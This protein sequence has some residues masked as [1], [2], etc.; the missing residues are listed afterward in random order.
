MVEVGHMFP[1]ESLKTNIQ[2][3]D[4]DLVLNKIMDLPISHWNYKGQL[5]IQH[6]GPMAQD[7]FEL[8]QFGSDS[9][10][11]QSVDMDGVILSGIK[12]LGGR[13]L[14]LFKRSDEVGLTFQE[15]NEQIKLV[16]SNY[17]HLHELDS[18]LQDLEIR[19][20]QEMSDLHKKEISQTKVIHRLSDRLS[21]YIKS[22]GR[23]S[24]D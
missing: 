10:Y 2:L 18:N 7:F 24:D 20:N 22:K 13:S 14:K 17:M 19:L 1:D 23:L 16:E 6:I 5:Y 15:L 3:V 12:A 8:F 4:H 11:I 21:R 9:R